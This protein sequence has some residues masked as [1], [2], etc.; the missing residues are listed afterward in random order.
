MKPSKW[1]AARHAFIS[2]GLLRGAVAAPMRVGVI[3]VGSVGQNH[4]RGY[5][6]IADLVGIADPDV[7]AGG[8]A[9]NRFNVSDYTDAPPLLKEELDAARVGV[10]TEDHVKRALPVI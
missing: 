8:A 7:K 9:S 5:S 6:G 1:A 3:G 2:G 10:P 4:A